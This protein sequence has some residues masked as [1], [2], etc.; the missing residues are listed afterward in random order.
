[1]VICIVLLV[2]WS[3]LFQ[4]LQKPLSD[5]SKLFHHQSPMRS[6][7]LMVP[8]A[9]SRSKTNSTMRKAKGMKNCTRELSFLEVYFEVW[10]HMGLWKD[11]G[12]CSIL[13]KKYRQ[14]FSSFQV[15][16]FWQRSNDIFHP[17]RRRIR[18]DELPPQHTSQTPHLDRVRNRDTLTLQGRNHGQG[19]VA[20]QAEVN[21]KQ[22]RNRRT[23]YIHYLSFF[24]LIHISQ[25]IQ[26]FI[27]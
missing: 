20:I 15:G 18:T 23:R 10:G 2:A 16:S 13:Q 5:W 24:A 22:R 11:G 1:M 4:N 21:S 26:H 9:N 17:S 25:T 12:S 8:K 27:L 6:F 14:I 3:V 19:K 7:Y